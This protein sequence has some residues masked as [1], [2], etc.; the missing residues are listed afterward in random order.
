M[1]LTLFYTPTSC[2]SREPDGLSLF[3]GNNKRL[4]PNTSHTLQKGNKATPVS[5]A[6]KYSRGIELID[7]GFIIIAVKKYSTR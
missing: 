4:R 7:A 6:D 5:V 1:V 3:M 2:L